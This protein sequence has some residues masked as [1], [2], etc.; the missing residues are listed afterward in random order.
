MPCTVFLPP[1]LFLKHPQNLVDRALD[2]R[3]DICRSILG[4][5]GRPSSQMHLDGTAGVCPAF[6]GIHVF[7]VNLDSPQAITEPRAERR[8]DIRPDGLG[9]LF[10][11]ADVIVRTNLEDQG[12]LL[13]Q[14]MQGKC[15]CFRSAGADIITLV[16]PSGAKQ[17]TCHPEKRTPRTKLVLHSGQS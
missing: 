6:R 17:P 13:E 3:V 7:Q 16:T 15:N 2:S 5:D 8:L 4:S 1:Q 11:I 14:V 9:E 10:T 12:S